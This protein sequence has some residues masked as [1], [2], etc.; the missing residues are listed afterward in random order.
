MVGRT[1]EVLPSDEPV[2]TDDVEQAFMDWVSGLQDTEEPGKIRAFRVPLDEQGRASHSA[3][4]QVRL[5]TWPIDQYDFDT[6]CTKI[7]KEYMLP[8]ENML[9]VRLIGTLT[10][11]NGVR[12]NKIVMLQRPN[13]ISAVVAP[14][15]TGG[16][17]DVLESM[18]KGQERMMR[19]FQ[20]MQG[21]PGD[22]GGQSEMMR[23][24][25]MM[26]VMMEPMTTMM[27]PILAAFAGRSAPVAGPTT[28]MRETMETFMLMDKFFGRRGN[29][30]RRGNVSDFAEIATA[31]SGVAKPMLEMAA[32]N[33]SMRNRNRL[34]A[35]SVQP[36][37]PPVAAPNQPATPQVAPVSTPV[38]T[39]APSTIPTGHDL[40]RPTSLGAVPPSGHDIQAPSSALGDTAM[41]TQIKTQV[42]GL[43]QVAQQNSDPGVVADQFFEDVLAQMGD[44]EYGILCSK[45]EDPNFMQTLSAYNPAVAQ[46]TPWFVSFRERLVQHIVQADVPA[47]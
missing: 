25:A 15:Q 43:L 12:F 19:I 22:N 29:E 8:T 23:M 30:G 40:S 14:S 10:G 39:P 17:G 4:G 33:M 7:M 47:P 37:T 20:E 13:T 31:V 42:D 16:L 35:S 28:S 41:F 18:Q 34:G 6:L 36:Q 46:F 38:A 32:A 2:Q 9:A 27:G 24:A 21:K 11:K 45:L 3:T 5:G 1:F 26:R 44:T